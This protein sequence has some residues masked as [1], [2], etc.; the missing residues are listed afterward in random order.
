MLDTGP[1]E[2][3]V[4][5]TAGSFGGATDCRD[6]AMRVSGVGRAIPIIDAGCTDEGAVMSEQLVELPQVEVR[7]A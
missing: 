4:P 2:R 7:G 1:R 5:T 3:A 6:V